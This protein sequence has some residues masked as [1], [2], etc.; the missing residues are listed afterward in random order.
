MRM[1]QNGLTAEEIINEYS[2]TDLADIIFQY[3]DERKSRKI[4]KN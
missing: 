1:S 3:G 4:A 2:E